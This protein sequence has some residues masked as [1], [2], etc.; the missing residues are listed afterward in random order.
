MEISKVN[1][2][3]TGE[4]KAKGVKVNDEVARVGVKAKVNVPSGKLNIQ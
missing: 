4:A 1:E 2:V 3:V